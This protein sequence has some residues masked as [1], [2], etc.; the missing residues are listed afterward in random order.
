MVLVVREK[1]HII[2]VY[3]LVEMQKYWVLGRKT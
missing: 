3:P 2:I 1:P